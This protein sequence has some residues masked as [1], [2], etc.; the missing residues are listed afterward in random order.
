MS[1]AAAFLAAVLCLAL[2]PA[3]QA[4]W[5]SREAA[6]MGTSV[7]VTAYHEQ[8]SRAARAVA[9]VLAELRRIDAAM[10]PYRPD[11][12]ISRVNARAAREPVMVSREFA[13]VLARARE[14]SELTGGAFDITYASV[15]HLYRFRDRRRPQAEAI[16]QRL[17]AVDYRHVLVNPDGPSVR[18]RQPGVRIDL[19]GIAKGYAV[20]RGTQVLREHGIAHGQVSAGGDTRLLGDRRGRPWVVGIQDPRDADAMVAR[21]PVVD[22]A[23]ST[24]G[25]YER[26]FDERG[27][28]Y[29]HI[30]DPDTGD[31]ARSVRSVTVLGPDAT[32]TDALSTSVFVLGPERGLALVETL[33]GFEAVVV[34]AAGRMRFSAGLRDLA[35]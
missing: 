30:L 1:R 8:D 4:G 35:D 9:A 23:V 16:Q 32:A 5:V 28:R 6:V 13:E 24:S 31:S 2:I 20:E 21:I 12:E 7:R 17:P 33:E 26:Y 11:S 29:H 10:S 25:D 22:E 34:D 27:V 3:A 15:G 19:G 14:F 18:F